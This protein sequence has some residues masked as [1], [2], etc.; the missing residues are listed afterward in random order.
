MYKRIVFLL[1]VLF[2]V[3]SFALGIPIFP[4]HL[5]SDYELPSKIDNSLRIKMM[6]VLS[7]TGI[8]S[9]NPY[10]ASFALQPQ[11]AINNEE[12]SGGYQPTYKITFDI[13][14][15]IVDVHTAKVITSKSYSIVGRGQ[16]KANAISKALM[17]VDI[18]GE[19]FFSFINDAQGMVLSYA[20]KSAVESINKARSAFKSHNYEQALYIL[21]TIP[22]GV[23]V[24]NRVL[25]E[26]DISYKAYCESRGKELLLKAKAVWSSKQNEEGAQEAAKYLM[27]IPV[28]SSSVSSAEY[29][30]K[31]MSRRI[32]FLDAREWNIIEKEM[33]RRHSEKKSIINGARDVAVAYAKN[34]PV[35][36]YKVNLWW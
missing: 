12:Y 23:S 34:R 16:S 33:E 18:N 27:D 28:Y 30:M 2:S 5:V 21:N 4:A 20:E 6:N 29:L 3:N 17:E 19:D 26:M 15:S 7:K 32:Q 13:T 11:I 10:L 9:I 14:F 31:E 22:D 25:E 8:S 24:Y 36:F 1:S 35:N